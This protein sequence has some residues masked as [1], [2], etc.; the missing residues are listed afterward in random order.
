MQRTV[1]SLVFCLLASLFTVSFSSFYDPAYNSPQD[2][3]ATTIEFAS[4]VASYV[5]SEKD[6]L[7]VSKIDNKTYQISA[8][9]PGMCAVKFTV[10]PAVEGPDHVRSQG[11]LFLVSENLHLTT[12]K[13]RFWR[14]GSF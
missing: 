3:D 12:Q 14:R 4:P 5:C 10:I 9:K 13:T 6:V 8:N 11:Y 7:V 1:F 2:T